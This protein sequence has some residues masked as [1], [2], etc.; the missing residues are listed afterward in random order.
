M[1]SLAFVMF[2]AAC[3]GGT[4]APEQTPDAGPDAP[5]AIDAPQVSVTMVDRVLHSTLDASRDLQQL[6]DGL[7]QGTD[8]LR[9]DDGTA[10]RGQLDGNEVVDTRFYNDSVAT[11]PTYCK[12]DVT[13]GQLDASFGTSGCAV[14]PDAYF[15]A[16]GIAKE[17]D[18]SYRALVQKDCSNG[19]PDEQQSFG[20]LT[21][22]AAGAVDPTIRYSTI[23]P[24]LSVIAFAAQST[25]DLVITGYTGL[26]NMQLFRIH[27]DGS[28]DTTFGTQGF[29]PD[30]NG[31]RIRVLADDTVLVEAVYNGAARIEHYTKDGQP[32]WI[33]DLETITQSTFDNDVEP[34][35]ADLDATGRIVVAYTRTDVYD[36]PKH[37]DVLRLTADGQLDTTFGTGGVMT[38]VGGPTGSELDGIGFSPDGTILVG[39]RLAGHPALARIAP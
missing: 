33:A 29:I 34:R 12:V 21:I 2:V 20:M 5:A 9:L 25:G 3:G 30:A 15:F 7:H 26:Y 4:R 16:A 11:P 1:K 8:G 24:D 35:G 37:I 27:A 31:G 14:G 17:P 6:D 38:D 32:I 18:G 28:L 22:S 23:L 19:C 13:T 39:L 36:G 10:L